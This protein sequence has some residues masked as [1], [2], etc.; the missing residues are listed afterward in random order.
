MAVSGQPLVPAALYP[1]KGPLVP[2]WWVAGWASELVSTQRLKEKKCLPGIEPLS[3]SLESD[4][5][6]RERVTNLFIKMFTCILTGNAHCCSHI[7]SL[8]ELLN[9]VL[10]L[11]CVV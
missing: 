7:G 11:W 3:S 2:I 10:M 1:R 8:T 5:V 9:C 6:L 4:T